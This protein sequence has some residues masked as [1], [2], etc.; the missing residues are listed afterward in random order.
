MPARATRFRLTVLATAALLAVLGT[1]WAL[2]Q[3]ALAAP[4]RPTGL[5]ATG[6]RPRHGEP[7][8]E[9]PRRG[10]MSS[11]HTLA[12]ALALLWTQLRQTVGTVATPV[13][14]L[15]AATHSLEQEST[16]LQHSQA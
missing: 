8:L 10:D 16:R 1:L 13:P 11:C 14:T 6:P 5:T 15:L 12:D 3:S 9:P 4:D 2:P 7:D